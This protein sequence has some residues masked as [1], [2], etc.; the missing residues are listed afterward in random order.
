MIYLEAT[1]PIDMASMLFLLRFFFG[2]I[3]IESSIFYLECVFFY[4]WSIWDDGTPPKPS[5]VP[6]SIYT[7]FK[8][9][10]YS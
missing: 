1:L 8:T 10:Y 2:V 6:T 5:F 9:Q 3:V 4:K 7:S